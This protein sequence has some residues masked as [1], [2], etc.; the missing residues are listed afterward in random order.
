M[1]REKEEEEEEEE[2]EKVIIRKQLAAAV[3]SI[4]WSYSIFWSLS[5]TLPGVLEWGDG[6]YNGDI[7]TRKTVQSAEKSRDDDDDDD[8]EFGLERTKQLRELYES[9]SAETNNIPQAKRPSASLSPEDLTNA[10]WYFLVCMSF[11]FNI[12]LG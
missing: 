10:E 2:E 7:K 4:Q 12:G 3:K 5:S 9:L 11:L 1:G 8:D 6:Y